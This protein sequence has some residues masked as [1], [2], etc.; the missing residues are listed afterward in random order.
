MSIALNCEAR[1]SIEFKCFKSTE[2]MLNSLI[3]G[4]CFNSILLPFTLSIPGALGLKH[5]FSTPRLF[6][7]VFILSYFRN[8]FKK[9]IVS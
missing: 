5:G 9:L 1:F 4:I 6:V 7:N 2:P 3:L 8:C